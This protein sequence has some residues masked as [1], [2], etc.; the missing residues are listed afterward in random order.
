[1]NGRIEFELNGIAHC[2]FFGTLA[3]RIYTTK[4]AEEF[5]RISEGK[6]LTTA[7]LVSLIDQDKSFAYIIYAG[8]CNYA[9]IKEQ[10]HPTFE[11]AYILTE[12]IFYSGN[13]QLAIDIINEYSE[14]R[15]TKAQLESMNALNTDEKKS[16][17][18]K[19]QTG[20]KSKVTPLKSA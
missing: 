8:L 10:K 5:E 3:V 4:S 13:K 18:P 1:M 7:E 2:L 12:S 19:K 17:N 11:E 6:K 15:A 20:M 14:S 9:E 16:E